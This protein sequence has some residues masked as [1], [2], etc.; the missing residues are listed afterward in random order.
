MAEQLP[1]PGVG[2]RGLAE[3]AEGVAPFVQDAGRAQHFAEEGVEPHDA[4]ARRIAGLAQAGAHHRHG[5]GAH[6]RGG[7][8]QAQAVFLDQ[9]LGVLPLV[10]QGRADRMQHPRP[11]FR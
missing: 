5:K 8:L 7:R 4:F 3:Q 11:L 9:H 10:P 6:R 2:G 1:A